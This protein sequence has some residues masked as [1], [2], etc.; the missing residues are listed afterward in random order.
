MG[1]AERERDEAKN[2]ILAWSD[3]HAD[4]EASRDAAL[5]ELAKL[6]GTLESARNGINLIG[7]ALLDFA[8]DDMQGLVTV[9]INTAESLR[10]ELE[11]AIPSPP[12]DPAK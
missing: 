9:A 1:E 8:G 2:N 4:M 11:A 6:R 12:K 10:V 3:A 7:T 5:S